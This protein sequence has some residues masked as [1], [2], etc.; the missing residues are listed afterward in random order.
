MDDG[1]CLRVP[2]TKV[3]DRK[4][5]G[6]NEELDREIIWLMFNVKEYK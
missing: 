2:I 3:R 1:H 4:R 5:D 6:C